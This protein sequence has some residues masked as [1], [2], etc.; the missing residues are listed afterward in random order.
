MSRW[1]RNELKETSRVYTYGN[2]H[3]DDMIAHTCPRCD[4]DMIRVGLAGSS[5]EER[6]R[7]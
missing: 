2:G 1:S 7:G 6:N 4:G 3:G 5:N